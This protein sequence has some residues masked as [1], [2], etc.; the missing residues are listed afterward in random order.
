MAAHPARR[1]TISFC[2]NLCSEPYDGDIQEHV[3][4]EVSTTDNMREMLTTA[5]QVNLAL[6]A[7]RERPAFVCFTISACHRPRTW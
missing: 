4:R 2:P 7:V 6:V 5:M 3:R 1:L